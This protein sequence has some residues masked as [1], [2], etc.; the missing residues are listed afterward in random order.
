[1]RTLYHSTLLGAAYQVVAVGYKI[2]S[3]LAA[4][5]GALGHRKQEEDCSKVLLVRERLN[6]Q[7]R[8][9]VFIQ[10]LSRTYTVRD[11]PTLELGKVL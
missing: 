4:R 8:Y 9:P 1:M 3:E 10:M 11:D 7:L 5:V 6:Q 2:L